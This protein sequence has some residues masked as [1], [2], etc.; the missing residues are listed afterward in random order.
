MQHWSSHLGRSNG[1]WPLTV[2]TSVSGVFRHALAHWLVTLAHVAGAPIQTVIVAHLS[3]AERPRETSGAAT[4]RLACRENKERRALSWSIH[5]VM[6]PILPAA[7]LFT[8][9]G[10]P[11]ASLEETMET[12]RLWTSPWFPHQGICQTCPQIQ[13]FR[14]SMFFGQTSVMFIK[15]WPNIQWWSSTEVDG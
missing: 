11:F 3:L 1:F 6:D 7:M 12:S 2:K 5:K 14:L 9:G 10:E 8:W 13:T 4:G 15:S